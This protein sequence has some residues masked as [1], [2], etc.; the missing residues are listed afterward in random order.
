MALSIKIITSNH[1]TR[2][3]YQSNTEHESALIE[4]LKTNSQLFTLPSLIISSDLQTEMFSPKFIVAIEIDSQDGV[5]FELPHTDIYFQAIG[6]G[7]EVFAYDLDFD[8]ESDLS[9]NIETPRRARV[10]F[11]FQGGHVVTTELVLMRED[12][13]L[14]ERT[15]RI[16]QAFEQPIIFYQTENKGLGLFNPHAIT[17]TV[18]TPRTLVT[19]TDT[20]IVDEY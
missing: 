9:S 14:A 20:I 1:V 8:T 3:F 12:V 15:S 13:S 10:E 7:D 18:I 6:S 16:T 17:R 11:Y 2:Q 4:K 19:P 5:S